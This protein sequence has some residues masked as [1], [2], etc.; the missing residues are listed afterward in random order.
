MWTRPPHDCIPLYVPD[1][2]CPT[3]PGGVRDSE[4]LWRRERCLIGEGAFPLQT[5]Y[6]FVLLSCFC[7]IIW[8]LVI[9]VNGR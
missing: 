3:Q 8:L 2:F 5:V 9:Q 6:F 1:N 4:Y 7:V